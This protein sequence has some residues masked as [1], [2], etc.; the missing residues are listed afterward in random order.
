MEWD[1]NDLDTS[2]AACP[3]TPDEVDAAII[4]LEE[5]MEPLQ[6]RHRADV[7]GFASAWAQHH[8][9]LIAAVPPSMRPEVEQRLHRIGIRWGVAHGTRMT[10]QF[11]A[12]KG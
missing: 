7:F 12:F 9:A 10:G 11:P 3:M 4:A 2:A 5:R 8:D 1:L 6:V